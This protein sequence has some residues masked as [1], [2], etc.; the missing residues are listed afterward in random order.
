MKLFLGV[1][2]GGT[3]TKCICVDDNLNIISSSEGEASNPLIVGYEKSAQTI[4]N[5]IENT[6]NLK[7]L[8]YCV[9]GVA[10]CGR[11]ENS[12]KLNNA[13]IKESNRRK[14]KLPE[15]KITSDIEIAHEAVFNG[16]EGAILIIG[17]GSILY[18]KNK[19]S[20]SL[21]VGGNG[22]L[23]GDEGS[24]YSIGQKGLR[25]AIKSFD[26]RNDKTILTDI[27]KK[28]FS[29]NNRD[30]L[31]SNLYNN[32]I[33]IQNFAPFVIKAAELNDK[34]SLSI[35]EEESNE[36]ILHINAAKNIFP[37][38]FNLCL[39]GSLIST[40]NFY[41]KLI[42]DKI[43]KHFSDIKIINA[44]YPPEFGAALIAKNLFNQNKMKK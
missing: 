21:I 23:I 6:C 40:N 17:T 20:D 39:V 36:I 27:L 32:K 7:E 26:G 1:D 35:L 43:K 24:G 2:G 41:S 31:I 11:K 3:K 33:E 14:I 38:G 22:R 28:E 19:N 4:L 12:E 42:K 13:I 44:K 16:K 15:F 9:I 25:A 34:I 29:I 37:N 8:S 10:G 30:E 5:L 18:L